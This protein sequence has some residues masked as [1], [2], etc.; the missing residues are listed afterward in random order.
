MNDVST[1]DTLPSAA[2]SLG[3]DDARSNLHQAASSAISAEALSAKVDELSERVG[4]LYSS[5]NTT[6]S[7]G[8][9]PIPSLTVVAAA[10]FVAGYVCAW[11]R[12]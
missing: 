8:V 6:I 2:E 12:A 7:R 11:L 9:D 1:N 4:R 5:A 10:G 3:N